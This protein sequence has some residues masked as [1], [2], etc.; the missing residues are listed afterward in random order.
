MSKPLIGMVVTVPAQD[1]LPK[2]RKL[3][4]A[5]LGAFGGGDIFWLGSKMVATLIPGG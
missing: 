4:F 1:D 3:R 5:W 2:A